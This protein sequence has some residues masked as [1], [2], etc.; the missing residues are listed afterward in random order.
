MSADKQ[1]I[2]A[3][4]T[5]FILRHL[6]R[7]KDTYGGDSAARKLELLQ[8]LEHR[9]LARPRE[10]F[11]LH[12]ILCFLR[13]FPDDKGVL[14]QVER[15]L[16]SFV[17]RADLRRHAQRERELEKARDRDRGRGGKRRPRLGRERTRHRERRSSR[18]PRDRHTL[19][20]TVTV[21]HSSRQLN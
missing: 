18:P 19:P 5:S 3:E 12:E 9:R 1:F 20:S 15:M 17:D 13:A 16:A 14:T 6:E 8:L 10:V 11:R 7:L 2:V 21:T 4:K